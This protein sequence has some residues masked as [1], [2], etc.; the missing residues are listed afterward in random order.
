MIST[1]VE[2]RRTRAR[3]AFLSLST[4]L[5]SGFA[6]PALAQSAPPPHVDVD[7]N[8]VDLI[9]GNYVTSLVEGSIGS[10]DGAVAMTRM[11][12]GAQNWID[13]WTGGLLFQTVSGSTTAY[14]ILGSVGDAFSVS[15]T[16]YTSIAKNGATL[17]DNAVGASP[18][19]LY[20]APDGTKI[21]FRSNGAGIMNNHPLV[22]FACA[23]YFSTTC[24]IP[25]S[26]TKPN[27]MKFTIGWTYVTKCTSGSGP[28]C[29]GPT[30]YY[31]FNGVTSSAGYGFTVSYLTN[32]AGNFSVPQT[33]WYYKTGLTFSNA[34]NTP[35]SS[36]VVTY[37]TPSS[38]HPDFTD[39]AGRTWHFVGGEQTLL[40]SI[41][42]PGASSA[43]TTISYSGTPSY[44]SSITINGVTTTYSRS[45]SGSTATTT[46]TDALSHQTI[47][48]AD[49]TLAR[50][51]KVTKVMS[52][53]N[54]VTTYGYD[55]D[56]HLT[57]VTNPEGDIVHYA[58]DTRGNVTST[59][60]KA[61]PG[62]VLPDIV[63]SATYPSSCSDAACN[64]PTATTDALGNQTD[65]SYD[66]PTGLVTKVTAPAPTSTVGA[67][68][69][70]TRYSYTAISGVTMLTG[71]STCQTGTAP[72]CVGTSDEIATTVGYDTNF[73]PN[74][75]SKGAGDGSLTATT[76]ITYDPVGNPLTVDGPLSG[77]ADTTTFRY[78]AARQRVGVIS[79]DP[80]GA[81][82]MKRRAIRTTYNN[83][84]QVTEAE[85]GTVNGTTDTDWAAF[86]SLQQSTQTY[87]ANARRTVSTTT[88]GG[89]TYNVAQYS[90]DA[91]G[92]P[93][94]SALRM[95]SATW[96]SLP[97]SACSL[98]TTGTFGPDRITKN[99]YDTIGRVTQVQ[100]AAGTSDQANE[101]TGTYNKNGTL[102]TLTDAEGNTTSYVYDDFD[103]LLQTR[104]PSTTA[105]S[106]T[107]SSTDYEQLS[108][109]A[110]SE[111][112][113]RRLRDGS[114]IGL[115]YDH[116]GRLTYK[117]L[118]TG[119]YDVTYSY[120]LTGRFTGAATSLQ[121]LTFGYD[122]LGRVTSQG[123]PLGTVSAQ[124]DVAGRRTRLTWPD[125]F[126]VSYDY[127]TLGEMTAM[128]ENGAASGIGVLASYTYDDLGRRTAQTLGNGT[129][130]TY[131][132]D[133]VSRLTAHALDLSGT[134]YDQTLGFSYSPSSQISATTRSNDSFAWGGAANRNDASSVNGLN[135]TTSVGAGS[136]SYESK[137]NLSST[138]SNSYTYSSENL[139]L[140][141]PS[142]A[143]LVYDPLLRLYQESG[144][145]VTTALLQYDG[146]AM[147][148]EYDT[149]AVLQR[150]YVHA[151]GVDAPLVEYDRGSGGSYTRTWLHADE[152]GSIVAQSN[153]SGVETT[154]NSYDEY[155]VP[156]SGNAGRFQYTGQAWLPSLGLYYYKAR[157]Y[158]ARL[159]RF[160]QTDPI[161]YDD[162]LNWYNYVGSD[163]VNGSD[164]SGLAAPPPTY[165]QCTGSRIPANCG[166][167]GGVA[168]G[169]S[170][171]SPPSFADTI[172]FA[173]GNCYGGSSTTDSNGNIVVSARVCVPLFTGS[174]SSGGGY[175]NQP[176]PFSLAPP[177]VVVVARAKAEPTPMGNVGAIP[178]WQLELF[179]QRMCMAA[180]G[181]GAIGNV[182]SVDTGV[183][184]GAAVSYELGKEFSKG[185][186]G[187]VLGRGLNAAGRS[188][189][190]V[191]IAVIV[192]GSLGAYRAYQKDFRCVYR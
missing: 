96:T 40:T 30:T 178:A 110:G 61:K 92:R 97:S 12:N 17:V 103:R 51:T 124:Y 175:T 147:I 184:A 128:R 190:G 101:A 72:T 65:Y 47:V 60:R 151:P 187:W 25:D 79:P 129:S 9:S 86:V 152:R 32:V 46:I 185:F 182:L 26:I 127:N 126:Y 179:S 10:G 191:L 93:E 62:S 142:S 130:T 43:S 37:P 75:V 135:Q 132:Y 55:T 35:A 143:S 98:G 15:G 54:L 116:L 2:R 52:P 137:G 68:R 136:L 78:D 57:D 49:L 23:L 144:S 84:G 73:Q 44:V 19:Y 66:A 154:I 160:M 53:A 163:P 82:S 34:N 63:T 95:N 20:T 70:E 176:S 28:T 7:G 140:T 56:G 167:G 166:E 113:N 119:E 59:T 4:I 172:G 150:R 145:S 106:G 33:N 138:G 85:V 153:D 180:I 117:D 41:Q 74:S 162:G 177:D 76:A 8:G 173:G 81:G 42:R 115:I 186:G 21:Q 58:Y 189:P 94:C 134:S 48:E 24:S 16:T 156:A 64:E 158:S 170:N 148:S 168:S 38:D 102:A 45:I 6:A 22:G 31:R 88:A 133:N 91:L 114:N 18:G 192:A 39:P 139:L 181:Q 141:G 99:T 165:P 69:P 87:D 112:T 13:N 80:D 171:H 105:G 11:R 164:P 159:G 107:S 27:G 120:D 118:P 174:T 50:V 67:A 3:R 14:V 122:A 90:Y 109:D 100:T 183:G 121:T 5:C 29:V 169:L 188:G 157:V 125:N 104:Y 149:S 161:G 108:Y 71:V 77:T 111:V 36:P 1:P 123:G 131:G 146:Q 89:N 83:D 155:G